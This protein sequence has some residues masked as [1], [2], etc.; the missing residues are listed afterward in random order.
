MTLYY[1]EGLAAVTVMPRARDFALVQARLST[2]E[3]G[4]ARAYVN[5][6]IQGDEIRTSSWM[7]SADWTQTPLQVLYKSAR[8]DELLAAKQ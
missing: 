4:A 1:L 5:G 2:A 7:P 8:L 3:F 6:L